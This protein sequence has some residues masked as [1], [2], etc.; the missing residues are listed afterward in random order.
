MNAADCIQL[1]VKATQSNKITN[2]QH[3]INRSI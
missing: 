1:V 2:N 3:V